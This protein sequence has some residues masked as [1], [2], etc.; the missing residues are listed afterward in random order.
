MSNDKKNLKDAN[1][2]SEFDSRAEKGKHDWLFKYAKAIEADARVSNSFYLGGTDFAAR[3]VRNDLYIKGQQPAEMYK[4]KP[5]NEEGDPGNDTAKLEIFYDTSNPIGTIVNNVVGAL[6]NQGYKPRVINM[7]PESRT[8][9]DKGLEMFKRKQALAANADS[10][11]AAGLDPSKYIKG[12]K[13][14]ITSEDEM[15]LHFEMNFKDD[16]AFCVQTL[17]DYILTSNRYP[18]LERRALRNLVA[19]GWLVVFVDDTHSGKIILR[20]EKIQNFRCSY[21]EQEDGSDIRWAYTARTWNINELAVAANNELTEA[22]LFEAA[23]ANWPSSSGQWPWGQMYDPN[24]YGT[25]RPWGNAQAKVM[26][27]RLISVNNTRYAKVENKRTNGVKL[28]DLSDGQESPKDAEIIEI[29]CQYTY[30]FKYVFGT[31]IIFDYGEKPAYWSVGHNGSVQ[32]TAKLGYHLFAPDIE[33]MSNSCLVDQL[34][35]LADRW[36]FTRI[37]IDRMI[38]QAHPAGAW[39]NIDAMAGAINGFGEGRLKPKDM[40]RMFQ[41]KGSGYYSTQIEGVNIDQNP[42]REVSESTLQS[43]IQMMSVLADIRSQME[44]ISGVPFGTIGEPSQDQ[45]VGNMKFAAVNRNN[46][47]RYIDIAYRSVMQRVCENIVSIVQHQLSEGGTLLDYGVAI[48]YESVEILKMSKRI[49]LI[50]LGISIEVAPDPSD[51]T[52]VLTGLQKAF[53]LNI[54]GAGDYVRIF[55][56]I[57]TSPLRAAKYLQIIENKRQRE[58]EQADIK[59]IMANAQESAKAGMAVEER[60]AKNEAFYSQLRIRELH[61]KYKLDQGLSHQDYMEDMKLLNVEYDRKE[62]LVELATEQATSG[63][64]ESKNLPKKAGVRLPS[65][66]S[67]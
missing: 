46:T 20:V 58:K 12:I 24:R 6:Q 55:E 48:G 26:D 22:Q 7:S 40:L 17:L 49:P 59:K 2:P 63:S 32:A 19:S 53:E 67:A 31:S 44:I 11:K 38:A 4:P 45:A 42:I 3:F 37:N 50:Q 66:P 1:F 13:Q 36:V 64:Y 54:I 14:I 25:S 33:N 16:E 47:L 10:L 18:E 28:L 8:E 65:I 51:Q 57:K 56:L 34:I 15:E 30:G 61:V 5:D 9:Y 27:A 35:G 52:A 23:K 62:D 41:L 43:V 60:K 21:F 39:I 29:P